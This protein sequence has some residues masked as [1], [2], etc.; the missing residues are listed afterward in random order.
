M[1]DLVSFFKSP[2]R[3]DPLKRSSLSAWSFWVMWHCHAIR[4]HCYFHFTDDK[5][6]VWKS[7]RA[8]LGPHLLVALQ[9][10]LKASDF[11]IVICITFGCLSG[12]PPP[13][14][15]L[16]FLL[17][18]LVISIKF[19]NIP[20]PSRFSGASFD[21]THSDHVLT[22]ASLLSCQPAPPFHFLQTRMET[23]HAVE[24]PKLPTLN[25]SAF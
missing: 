24:R 17:L 10:N 8:S 21:G 15:L 9:L 22:L 1:S 2:S 12:G 13:P 19:I 3:A 7:G 14:H 23:A 16:P 20:S 18:L 5:T 25:L 6:E 4:N 11:S